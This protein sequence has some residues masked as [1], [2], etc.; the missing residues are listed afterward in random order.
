MEFNPHIR[1]F[2]WP[3]VAVIALVAVAGCTDRSG[4]AYIEIVNDQSALGDKA[5]PVIIDPR[6]DVTRNEYQRS[7]LNDGSNIRQRI[8]IRG[9]V[10]IIP[11]PAATQ[12][13]TRP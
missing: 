8:T 7:Y 6:V 2:H 1:R 9:P 10:M 3:I 11:L 5:E 4:T 13:S 12:P